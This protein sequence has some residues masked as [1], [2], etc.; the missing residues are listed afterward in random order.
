MGNFDLRKYLAEGRLLKEEMS[1]TMDQL[2]KLATIKSDEWKESPDKIVDI[3]MASVK[4]DLEQDGTNIE[5]TSEDEIAKLRYKW[6]RNKGLLKVRDAFT[7]MYGNRG[8]KI[9]TDKDLLKKL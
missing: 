9:N 7:S 2:K 1:L 3:I 5:N 8:E 6:A 4:W